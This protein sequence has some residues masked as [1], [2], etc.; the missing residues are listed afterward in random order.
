MAADASGGREDTKIT[1]APRNVIADHD[2]ADR[3][4]RPFPLVALDTA[5]VHPH[6]ESVPERINE[7]RKHGAIAKLDYSR[8]GSTGTDGSRGK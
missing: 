4:T 7:T 8:G 3:S 6:A 2:R 5:D 1:S